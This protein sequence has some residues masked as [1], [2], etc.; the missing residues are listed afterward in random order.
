M[1][2]SRQALLPAP[3]KPVFYSGASNS[4]RLILAGRDHDKKSRLEHFVYNTFYSHYGARV[5]HFMPLM[6]AFEQNDIL[7]VAGVRSA[8]GSHLFLEQYLDAPIEKLLSGFY[9]RPVSREGI[10][11]IGNLSSTCLGSAKFLFVALAALLHQAEA[12]WVVCVAN[13]AVRA[14]FRKMKLP[15]DCVQS[16]DKARLGKE[17]ELWGSYYDAGCCLMVA[18]VAECVAALSENPNIQ[19]EWQ[20]SLSQTRISQSAPGHWQALMSDRVY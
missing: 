16:V 9:G 15:F 7:A 10:V 11:E 5:N 4:A 18:S 19:K 13:P 20:S 14:I 12:Q 6:L 17:S 3:L 8:C 1:F 2:S